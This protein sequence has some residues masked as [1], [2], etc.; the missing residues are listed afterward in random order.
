MR[1][2]FPVLAALTTLPTCPYSKM[3]TVLSIA[4]LEIRDRIA[5]GRMSRA[6]RDDEP[7]AAPIQAG[8]RPAWTRRLEVKDLWR[9]LEA[10]IEVGG[11]LRRVGAGRPRSEDDQPDFQLWCAFSA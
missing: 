2:L 9:P 4:P 3:A 5:P 7:L 6:R 1:Y 10:G 11:R 8:V